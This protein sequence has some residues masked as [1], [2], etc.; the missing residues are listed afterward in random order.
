[1]SIS[2]KPEV[3]VVG[4][5]PVGKLAALVLA[6]RG[7]QVAIADSGVWGNTHS[8]ALGLHPQTLKLLDELEVLDRVLEAAY[9]VHSIGLWD[10]EDR[11]AGVSLAKPGDRKGSVAVLRQN[12]LEVALEKALASLGVDVSWSHEVS[13]LSASGNR[14]CATVD[15]YEKQ[16]MGYAVAHT[17]WV[18]AKS[19]NMEPDF[20]I[21]ADGYNSTVRRSL[22][23]DFPEVGPAQYYAVFE[24]KTNADLEHEMRLVLGDNTVDTLWP[25]PGGFCRWSFQLPK[26]D[27]SYIEREKDRLVMSSAWRKF[28]VLAESNLRALISERAPWFTGSVDEFSWRIVVRFEHRLAPGF[29]KGRMWIAGDAAHLTGPAG[30]QSMNAGFFEARDFGEAM[31]K[32]LRASGTTAEL[33][34]CGAKWNEVWRRLLGLEGRICPRPDAH[35]L[36]TGYAGRLVECMPAHGAELQG[37]LGQ[38]GVEM[39]VDA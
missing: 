8:Y 23:Y 34:A 27:S 36:V 14:V 32:V 5:G 17:E 7:I 3:L 38:L 19:L 6:R 11:R 2:R 20:V 30:M 22:E 26:Y 12:E 1:M 31:A 18:V 35:P 37:L 33:E 4:A 25:L 13:N 24:F 16:S 28:P 29:G 21:G 15:K 9:P 10:K 39:R